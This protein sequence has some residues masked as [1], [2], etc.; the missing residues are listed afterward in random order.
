M[1]ELPPETP[2]TCHVIGVPGATQSDAVKVCVAPRLTLAVAGEREF[3][4]AQ[5]IVTAAEADFEGSAALVASIVTTPEEGGI[6]GAVYVAES[7]PAE[8]IVPTVEF[9]P[10]T[11]LTLQLTAEFVIEVPATLAVKLAEPPGAK[12]A[13]LGERETTMSLWIWTMAEPDA[14]GA[15]WLVAVTDT[16]GGLGSDEG[17]V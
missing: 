6:A 12:L 17:A 16:L 14:E 11:L 1:M 2:L 10:G 4:A 9:P 8:A 13:E 3:A 5:E 15:D 7:A